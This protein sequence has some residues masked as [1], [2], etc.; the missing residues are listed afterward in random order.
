MVVR[1]H[2]AKPAVTLA[3]DDTLERARHALQGMR[4][5]GFPVVDAEGLLIGVVM[6]AEVFDLGRPGAERVRDLVHRR[7]A[8][9]FDDSSLREVADHMVDEGVGRLPVV[10]RDAPR[11]VLGVISRSDLLTAHRGRI[12]ERERADPGLAR[13]PRAA[14]RR[15]RGLS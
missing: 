2:M 12:D 10:A 9:A 11:R 13:L 14:L 8:V 3:A 4:H 1:D 5:Q 7:P 15:S 6:R